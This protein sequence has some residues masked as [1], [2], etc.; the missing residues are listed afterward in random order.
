MIAVIRIR[1]T[2]RITTSVV[3][4]MKILGLSKTHSCALLENN[5]VT[6]GMLRKV[7]DYVTW[8]E[9]KPDVLKLLKEKRGNKA[10][11]ESKLFKLA[12]PRGG[13]TKRGI[14][15]G[16]RQGGELGNRG[17]KINEL[18]ERMI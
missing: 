11:K 6:L 10:D 14:I 3:D 8:G 9:I 13:S 1:G 12:P 18:I 16:F 15:G 7:K 17:E 5:P 4:T 2:G